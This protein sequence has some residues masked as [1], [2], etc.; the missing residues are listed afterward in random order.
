MMTSKSKPLIAG[1]LRKSIG[2]AAGASPRPA[3]GFSAAERAAAREAC[4]DGRD[5][6]QRTIDQVVD[7][8]LRELTW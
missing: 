2:P 4:R 8:L 3:Q 7:R 1:V 5:A 6:K